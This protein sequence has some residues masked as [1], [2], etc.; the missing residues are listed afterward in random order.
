MEELKKPLKLITVELIKVK[1]ENAKKYLF[2]CTKPDFITPIFQ[3]TST[4]NIVYPVK[5]ILVID[6][7][8]HNW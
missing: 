3:Q 5:T 8:R 1:K 4:R 2:N 6:D 7:R